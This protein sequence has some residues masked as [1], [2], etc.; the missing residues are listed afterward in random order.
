MRIL[1]APE[2]LMVFV[3]QNFTLQITITDCDEK[4]MWVS[5]Q[6]S[7]K[8]QSLKQSTIPLLQNSSN[9]SLN[10]VQP[11]SSTFNLVVSGSRLISSQFTPPKTFCVSIC[12]DDIP[13][14]FEGE[15]IKIFYE[16]RFSI[17]IAGQPVNSISIPIKFITKYGSHFDLNSVQSKSK[18][19]IEAFE[20]TSIPAPFSLESPFKQTS[21]KPSEDIT[22]VKEG[23][24]IAIIQM[25]NEFCIGTE[26]TGLIDLRNI[27]S[28]LDLVILS[29]CRNEIYQNND[30]NESAIIETLTLDMKNNIARRFR[31]PLTFNYVSDFSS[32][33]FTVNYS[34]NF[35]FQ[36]GNEFTQYSL[37]LHIYPPNLC[38]T[39]PRSPLN[40]NK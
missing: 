39:T 31:I 15:A 23:K 38:L 36:N 24:T 13:P 10:Q 27:Q 2:N 25:T 18:F 20:S 1:V 19:Q 3:G 30:I 16:L 21:F 8:I 26:I 34:L 9:N 11:N 7:G 4:I 6:I 33:L 32:N 17:Q 40:A 22:V 5:G 12:A 35:R 28:N 14:S 37:P 29:I